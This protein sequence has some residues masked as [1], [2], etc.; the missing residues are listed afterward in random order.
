MRKIIGIATAL[1]IVSSVLGAQ[2]TNAA[3]TAPTPQQ[4]RD[5]FMMLL[6]RSGYFVASDSAFK[7]IY[8]NGVVFGG[9]FRLGGKQIAGWLEGNYLSRTGKSSYTKEE[10][11][12]KIIAIEA[13]ALYRILSGNISPYVAAGVGYYMFDENNSFIGEAKQ[14][15]VGFC[16][17][18]GASVILAKFLV[19]DARAKYS[20]CKMK[21][22]DYDIDVGGL[23]LGLGLGVRF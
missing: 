14:N 5:S 4:E 23:T 8:G 7:D 10:T 17:A 2:S 20:T 15:K 1:L 21:P 9:E 16:G 13:G 18:V 6:A 11:K 22:A 12:V 19:V 3:G